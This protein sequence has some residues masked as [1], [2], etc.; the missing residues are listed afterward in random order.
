MLSKNRFCRLKTCKPAKKRNSP[1][2]IKVQRAGTAAS[3]A[4]PGV[5]ENI[6]SADCTPVYVLTSGAI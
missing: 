4:C 5:Q 3:V 6:V 2:V 1:L